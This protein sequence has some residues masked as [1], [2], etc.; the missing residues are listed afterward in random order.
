MKKVRLTDMKKIKTYLLAGAMAAA[1]LA[2]TGCGKTTVNLNEY[3]TIEADGYDSLGTASYTFDYDAFQKDYS[4]KIKLNSKNSSELSAYGLLAGE[5]T[6]ELLL[7]VCVDCRLDQVNNLSNGDTV[8]L[9]WSCEDDMADEYFNCKLKYSDIELKVSGLE[10]VGKFN[11][12]DYVEIT[13]SG[14]S[15]SA[16]MTINPNYDQKEMQYVTFSSDKTHDLKNGDTFTVTA[17]IT[18]SVDTF[19]ENFGVILGETEKEYTVDGLP[20]YATKASDIPS[21]TLD[22]MV[23]QGEDVFRAQVANGWS[24][25]ES[26]VDVSYIGNYFLSP[27]PDMVTYCNNYIYLIYKITANNPDP[28]ETIT[29]YFYASFKDISVNPDDNTANVDLSDCTVPKSGWFSSETFKVGGYTYPGYETLDALASACVTT[30][31]DSY[32]YESSIQE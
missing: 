14:M 24:K 3:I 28:A 27:K 23:S 2:L 4:K 8:T 13:F 15:P 21:A 7:D 1:M 22:S 30:K 32:Q 29:Y 31:I 18:S 19:V 26:L 12:F 25:P 11:P 6:P 5:T 20:Y 9:K 10:E 17:S 16:S